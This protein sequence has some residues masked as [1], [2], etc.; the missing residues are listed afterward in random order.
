MTFENKNFSKLEEEKWILD[1]IAI[2]DLQKTSKL[3]IFGYDKNDN[4]YENNSFATKEELQDLINRLNGKYR[5][6]VTCS[7]FSIESNERTEEAAVRLNNI[8][9]DIDFNCSDLTQEQINEI[10]LNCV[11]PTNI[12]LKEKDVYPYI[13]FSG[14]KGMH[15]IIPVRL[16]LTTE[17]KEEI[18]DIIKRF[19]LV[20]EQKFFSNETATKYDVIVDKTRPLTDVFPIPFTIHPKTGNITKPVNNYLDGY[21]HFDTT[22]FK[23]NWQV[24]CQIAQQMPAKNQSFDSSFDSDN[25]SSISNPEAYKKALLILIKENFVEG[26]RHNF[27]V[28]FSGFLRRKG[29]KQEFVEELFAEFI[30]KNDYATVKDIFKK[31]KIP[32][33]PF[34]K[35]TIVKSDCN[36]LLQKLNQLFPI[37]KDDTIMLEQ[38]KNDEPSCIKNLLKQTL[39]HNHTSKITQLTPLL[40]YYNYTSKKVYS[41]DEQVEKINTIKKSKDDDTIFTNV[42]IENILAKNSD[43]KTLSICKTVLLPIGNRLS[44]C[45]PF[46]DKNKSKCPFVIKPEEDLPDYYLK[47]EDTEDLYDNLFYIEF[48][49]HPKEYK[50][51]YFTYELVFPKE[52]FNTDSNKSM[53]LATFELDTSKIFERHFF[54]LF[55]K[56]IIIPGEKRFEKQESWNKLIESWKQH[57]K[58]LF[59]N[60][61]ITYTPA[62][63]QEQFVFA[64]DKIRNRYIIDPNNNIIGP[65]TWTPDFSKGRG[66][67]CTEYKGEL[68]FDSLIEESIFICEEHKQ[69]YVPNQLILKYIKDSQLKISLGEL[70][71]YL[72]EYLTGNTAN[73]KIN[74]INLKLWIFKYSQDNFTRITTFLQE[75]KQ[76]EKNRDTY[77]E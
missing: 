28:G 48:K 70:R 69:I 59:I 10:I 53:F 39:K 43:K 47:I 77:E 72:A 46:E 30:D 44:L 35:E 65:V 58:I 13:H 32:G 17:N 64:I 76:K 2:T 23:T 31:T 49:R 51:K 26:Q 57:E 75:D 19:R 29:F 61:E 14:N 33:V 73:K 18:K 36:D 25:I 37:K 1:L 15:L 54:E 41:I 20:L 22:I 16:D 7:E 5:L 52:R 24:V 71:T 63:V 8:L 62:I 34:L 66:L 42:I 4:Y 3:F 45:C 6:S 68:N 38:P 12:Y 27:L 40:L 74:G 9:I 11:G 21:N 67:V 55:N 50:E 60:E 56:K